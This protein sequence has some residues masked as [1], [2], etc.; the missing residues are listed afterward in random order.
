MAYTPHS[1][2]TFGGSVNSG[3]DAEIWQCGIR[4]ATF[5][6]TSAPSAEALPLVDLTGYLN[7]ITGGMSSW[8]ST[9]ANGLRKDCTLSWLKVANIGA[10]GKYSGSTD[11]HG[12][13]NPALYSYATP[14]TGGAPGTGAVSH[15]PILT[16][17]LTFRTAIARGKGA[18]GRI[19][20]PFS[21]ALGNNTRISNAATFAS[22]GALL[23]TS[24]S[25]PGQTNNANVYPVVASSGGPINKINAVWVGDVV[26]VQRRRKDALIENY[27][28]LA[29]S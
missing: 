13:P 22:S 20:P 19:Y 2:L 24:I 9:T 27:T 16:V 6:D 11:Q 23:L 25:K 21:L 3:S 28:K 4:L 1:L 10:D 15:P 12:G 7:S 26:D 29:W 8:F 14:V 17:C 5:A 18:H